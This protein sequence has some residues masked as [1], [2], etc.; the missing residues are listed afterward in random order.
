LVVAIL[1]KAAHRDDAIRF[2]H[3]NHGPHGERSA[4]DDVLMTR[5]WDHD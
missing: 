3:R 4:D 1:A 5:P 2:V